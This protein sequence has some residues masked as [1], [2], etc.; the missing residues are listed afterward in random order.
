MSVYMLAHLKL[1]VDD[2]L[3]AR[4]VCGHD[5]IIGERHQREIL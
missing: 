2:Y 1:C 4:N 5:N 3:I